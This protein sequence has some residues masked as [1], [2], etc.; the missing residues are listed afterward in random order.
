[1]GGIR[2][3]HRGSRALN[4]RGQLERADYSRRDPAVNGLQMASA[5]LEIV[6]GLQLVNMTAEHGVE[7]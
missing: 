6:A 3:D 5:G 1:M 7:V 4:S 2:R